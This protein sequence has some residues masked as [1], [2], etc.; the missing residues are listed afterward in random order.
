MDEHIEK[1]QP[2]FSGNMGGGVVYILS[3]M[4]YL[5]SSFIQSEHAGVDH[6]DH[7]AYFST[8]YIWA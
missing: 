6:G 7:D 8:I 3:I 5:S 4:K 1:Y 2:H